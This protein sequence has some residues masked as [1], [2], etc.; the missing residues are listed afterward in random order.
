MASFEICHCLFCRLQTGIGS[1]VATPGTGVM[2][3]LT[4]LEM[5]FFPTV[6]VVKPELQDGDRTRLFVAVFNPSR[7]YPHCAKRARTQAGRAAL[8][9]TL[10]YAGSIEIHCYHRL[11]EFMTGVEIIH[12]SRRDR[13][14]GVEKPNEARICAGTLWTSRADK[15]LYRGRKRGTENVQ[16]R[17][18][19]VTVGRSRHTILTHRPH[20]LVP[21]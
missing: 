7:L 11:P 2:A 3:S 14:E 16:G 10:D 4:L 20:A 19:V 13:Y 9:E 8:V 18:S 12:D 6:G 21:P 15:T 1:S 5:C 17:N